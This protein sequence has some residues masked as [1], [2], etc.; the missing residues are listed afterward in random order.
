M[1]ITVQLFAVAKQLAQREHIEFDVADTAN[2]AEVREGLANAI[3]DLRPV[4]DHM[5]F[6]LDAE[7]ARD[8]MPVA[9][10]SKIACI[11]PVSGG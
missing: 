7:F 6:A 1:K 4:I 11:P 8:E 2:I 3:P 5:L 9:P 10:D